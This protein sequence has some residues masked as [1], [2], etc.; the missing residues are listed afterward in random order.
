MNVFELFLLLFRI[1][2]SKNK[3]NQ[4]HIFTWC[5]YGSP[6]VVST[7]NEPLRGQFGALEGVLQCEK[8]TSNPLQFL[9]ITFATFSGI[10]WSESR[11]LWENGINL[12][13]PFVCW[14]WLLSS[15][16]RISHVAVSWAECF[17]WVAQQPTFRE[18]GW[19]SNIVG[20]L[21]AYSPKTNLE[22]E[23]APLGK[24][25]QTSM[26]NFQPFV[27]EGVHMADNWKR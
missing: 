6:S 9:L 2:E 19:T 13:I 8:V 26:F 24:G 23:H 10:F 17:R 27:F 5:I 20:L 18:Q 1:I 3:F 16:G 21:Y 7:Q 15:I 12:D 4:R 14:W 25:K 11:C 22:T